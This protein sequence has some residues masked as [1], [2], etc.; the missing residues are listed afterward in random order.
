VIDKPE[1]SIYFPAAQ[2]IRVTVARGGGLAKFACILPPKVAQ[3]L[4]WSEPDEWDAARRKTTRLYATRLLLKQNANEIGDREADIE[5][6]RAENFEVYR[7]V[8]SGGKAQNRVRFLV[9]FNCIDGA[10]NLEPFLWRTLK[11]STLRI[12]YVIKPPEPKSR[13]LPGMEVEQEE[14]TVE[15]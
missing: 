10:A 12:F 9:R 2:L 13:K 6:T 3:D 11:P 7:R 15:A 4:H 14:E 5:I 1:L 8:Q